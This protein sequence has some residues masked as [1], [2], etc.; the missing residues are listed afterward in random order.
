MQNIPASSFFIVDFII[1]I[2]IRTWPHCWRPVS[3]NLEKI[4]D[5][6]TLT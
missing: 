6:V 4:T 1:Y 3:N 5:L 2:M